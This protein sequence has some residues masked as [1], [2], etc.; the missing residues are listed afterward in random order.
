MADRWGGPPWVAAGLQALAGLASRR[1]LHS[2]RR[3]A[4]YTNI[5]PRAAM[6]S[7]CMSLAAAH[8]L[9]AA[10]SGRWR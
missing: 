5:P 7:S 3:Q 2:R 9:S 4:C 8:K 10:A 1:Q 6:L